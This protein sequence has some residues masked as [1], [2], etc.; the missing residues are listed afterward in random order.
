MSMVIYIYIYIGV[1]LFTYVYIY[2]YIN[3][4]TCQTTS[5]EAPRGARRSSE[6]TVD[7]LSNTCGRENFHFNL[8][9]SCQIITFFFLRNGRKGAVRPPHQQ[10]T[11][12]LPALTEGRTN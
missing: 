5:R 12:P 3:V 10:I 8:T 4:K 9:S 2:I 11:P 6:A 1:H 7:M